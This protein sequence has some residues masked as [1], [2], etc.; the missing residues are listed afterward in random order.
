MNTATTGYYSLI[1]YCPDRGR[2]EAVNM[3]VL[4]FCPDR[5]YLRARFSS[6][7]ERIR[8]FFGDEAGD[9]KQINAMKKMLE[10]RL[11]AEQPSLGDLAALRRFASLMANEIVITDPRPALVEEP[12]VE[13]SQLFDE[14][15]GRTQRREP[16]P[17]ATLVNR[18]RVRMD[19]ARFNALIKRDVTVK[20]PVIGTEFTVPFAYQNGKLNLI[21]AHEFNQHREQDI[22]RDLLTKAAQGHLIYTHPDPEAGQRQLVVVASFGQAAQGHRTRV[23]EVLRDHNVGFFDESAFGQLEQQ[24]VETAH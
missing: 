7:N 11:K 12:D 17:E 4:L 10:H 9:L 22:V 3:G 15:V 23:A 16:P 5:G 19:A 24:I 21:E 2:L 1:Q 8:Q 6:S 14:L 18:L 20:V 13:L